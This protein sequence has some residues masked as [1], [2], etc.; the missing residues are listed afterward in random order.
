V[1]MRNLGKTG[2]KISRLGVGT[3]EIGNRLSRADEEQAGEVLNTALDAGINFVDTAACY[4]VAEE[5]IGATIAHRRDEFVLVTKA[6]H[7][8][9][10]YQGQEWTAETIQDSINR[11]LRRMRTDFLDLVQLHSCGVDVLER[12]EVIRALQDARQAG[13]TRFIGYSGDNEAAL[14]AVESGY[15]D[16][17]QTSFNLV[18]QRA[19]YGLLAKA[20]A[21]N[22]GVI[23]KR[24]IAN[25]AW[26]TPESPSGYATEYFRRYQKMAEEGPLPGSV[27]DG[28]LLALGFT[29]AHAA[30]DTMIVGTRDPDHM[31]TNI[32]WFN[33]ALPIDDAIVEE[34][35]RRYDA[36]GKEW[37][38]KT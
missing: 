5:L 10:G 38:Q 3:S 8:A 14:W 30:V 26:G 13:K 32:R 1:E 29:Y 27:E 24:P 31:K 25:G 33:E 20:R 22:M 36:L 6:G 15:F 34:L 12:G 35:H 4:G 19:R 11:S 2:L 9:G 23:A 16:T 37:D 21:Q 18:E 17:L 28:I 7:V